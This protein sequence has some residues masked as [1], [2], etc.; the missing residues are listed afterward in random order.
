MGENSKIEWTDHTFNPWRG[1]TKV[2][3]GCANCYAD[4][5]AKRNPGALGIWG[6]HGTRVLASDAMWR[7][8]IKWN[9]AAACIGSFDCNAGSHSDACPQSNR[10]RV[11]CASMADVFEDWQG[12]IRNPAGRV[13][14]RC[15]AGH[16]LPLDSVWVNGIECD[17]GCTLLAHPLTMNDVRNDL[18]KMI[19]AT[20]HL[21]W[22]LLTKRPENIRRFAHDAWT[23]KV[24]GHVSQNEG[25]GRRWKPRRNVWLGTSIA[26]QE[27]ADKNIPELLKC[28]E[29]SS[30]LFVSAEPLLGEVWL[31]QFLW[32]AWSG[33]Q[34]AVNGGQPIAR[35]GVWLIVGGESGPGAR[36]MHPAW[37]RSLRDQCQAAGVPFFFKQWGE[38]GAVH[39]PIGGAA[40]QAINGKIDC[41]YGEWHDDSGF[42][43]SCLCG[44]GHGTVAKV[45][46]AAAGRLLDGREWNEFPRVEVSA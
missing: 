4:K 44:A 12:E 33:D 15:S 14:H 2:A 38:W 41:R 31:T 3:A 45:G 30:V 11:F 13:L 35:T 34:P 18:F 29:L 6:D 40:D 27:D 36:P 5:Q 26:T 46:K 24:S 42:V 10:P 22:L 7:E 32:D 20:P 28:R 8:P 17:A 16:I 1:C 43:E 9:K 39:H 25:D 21:D 37:A 23:E 19:D